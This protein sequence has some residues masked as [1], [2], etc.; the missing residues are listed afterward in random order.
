MGQAML[1]R[2]TLAP[3]SCFMPVDAAGNAGTSWV[4][5]M[6]RIESYFTNCRNVNVNG[7]FPNGPNY[8]QPGCLCQARN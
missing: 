2:H 8:M 4:K 5:A 7:A 3:A 1:R 6:S